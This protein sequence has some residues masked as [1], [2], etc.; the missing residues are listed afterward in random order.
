MRPETLD[1][2]V[3]Q[4]HIL[5]PGKPLRVQIEKDRLTSIILWGPPGVGKTTLASLVARQTKCAFIPFSAVLSGI[6]EIKGVMVEAERNRRQGLRTV[7][8]VDEIHRFNKAQQDAFL[9]YVERG[10][11][12]LIGATTENPSFEVISALLSRS[13]VYALRALTLEE[14]VLLLRRALPVVGIEAEDD[15]LEQIGAYAGGDARTAYNILEIAAAA[16][17][18]GKLERQAVEDAVERKMLLYDK[19]GEEH[20]NLV[21]ALHKSVR[22][23]DPDAALYWLA[24]MLEAGEDRMY[25]ARRLV[26][27]AV[28]DVGLADPRAAEQ[29]IACMQTVHF[30]GVPE[31]DQALAQAAVYLA[32]APKSDAGYRAL[33]AAREFVRNNAAFPVP[34]HLRNAPTRAMKEWG[35]SKGYEHAHANAAGLTGMDCLPD[36]MEG[37]KFYEPS[38]RGTEARIKDRLEEIRKWVAE[39]RSSE[40][41]AS[42]P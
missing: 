14:L 1:G 41:D 22:S 35:Y 40:P 8:F 30:L 27:M 34:M 15:L 7:L 31:G 21:S 5:G 16:S 42:K 13:K 36:G 20:F 32:V 39:Q 17:E 6:K 25:L 19:G 28:E 24:R 38:A 11:I 29:A 3:G 23:S 26:R 4:E 9:P 37:I 12:I 33:N 2:Y 10:D 18:S